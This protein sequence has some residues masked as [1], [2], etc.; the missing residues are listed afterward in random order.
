MRISVELGLEHLGEE[1]YQVKHCALYIYKGPDM[2]A[3]NSKEMALMILEVLSTSC[4]LLSSVQSPF[5]VLLHKK[6]LKKS[7]EGKHVSSGWQ[8]I[9]TDF[10]KQLWNLCNLRF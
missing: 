2:V 7:A 1:F 4:V 10:L 3:F 5:Q 6:V 9:E 8:N